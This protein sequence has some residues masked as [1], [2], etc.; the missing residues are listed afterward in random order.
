MY[1]H[2]WQWL[3]IKHVCWYVCRLVNKHTNNATM[4]MHGSWTCLSCSAGMHKAIHEQQALLT[5]AVPL[6]WQAQNIR[7]ECTHAPMERDGEHS[8]HG[9]KTGGGKDR[10]EHWRK[11]FSFVTVFFLRCLSICIPVK[12]PFLT[13]LVFSISKEMWP[14]IH[15]KPARNKFQ[16]L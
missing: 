11:N 9:R 12:F 13:Y 14:N 5:A 10:Q 4:R 7:G 2:D 15:L 8:G 16:W 6:H 3:C 1:T